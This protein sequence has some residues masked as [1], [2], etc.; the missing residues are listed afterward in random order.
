MKL[1]LLTLSLLFGYTLSNACDVT[2]TTDKDKYGI[3][4]TAVLTVTVGL[5]HG[6]CVRETV[7]PVVSVEGATLTA[8]TA[9]KK[10]DKGLYEI[11]Y[12]I[13]ITHKKSHVTIDKICPKGGD[14]TTLTFKVL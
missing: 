8:K 3:N 6:R 9:Y 4:D 14:S 5:T 7:E 10:N 2:V 13:T 11:K 12:K 1:F